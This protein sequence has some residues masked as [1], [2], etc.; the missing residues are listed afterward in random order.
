MKKAPIR[1]ET[2]R[3]KLINTEKTVRNNISWDFDCAE[4]I[5][6]NEQGFTL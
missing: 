1:T 5:N 4:V 3:W 2:E 6:N